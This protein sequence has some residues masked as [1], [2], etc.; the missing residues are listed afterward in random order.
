MTR[1]ACQMLPKIIIITIFPRKYRDANQE[2]YGEIETRGYE[3]VNSL[4]YNSSF[5]GNN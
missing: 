4:E 5:P 1:E 3:Y 2:K